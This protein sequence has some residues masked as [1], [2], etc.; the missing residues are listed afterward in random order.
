MGIVKLD[1]NDRKILHALDFYS[2]KSN[3][4]IGKE[5]RLSKEVVNYRI[6]R[7]AELG[8]LEYFQTIVNVAKLGYTTF[9]VYLRLQDA[10]HATVQEITAFLIQ[11]PKI[12]W[13]AN[14][15][16]SWNLEFAVWGRN[17][18][19]FEE[20]WHEFLAKYRPFVSASQISVYTRLH[21]F[22]RSF[23]VAGKEE[24]PEE[25]VIG[26]KEIAKYDKTDMGILQALGANGRAPLLEIA[27]KAGISP[28]VAAYRIKRMEKEGIILGYKPMIN[29]AKIGYEYYK[30]N[31][32]LKNFS[33]V[34]RMIAW[35]RGNQNIVYVDETIAGADFE[36]DAQVPSSTD[37][38]ALIG[39]FM[40]KF[41]A[42]I[43]SYDYFR[44]LNELKI[45]YVP[46]E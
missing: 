8:V 9:R 30:V 17:I 33:Q 39:E 5:V 12:W 23:L 37:Y 45:I 3:A 13:I 46:Q 14:S 34:D 31:V 10:D 20:V 2:R 41:G 11:H 22:R 26:G 15:T 36:F 19:E 27:A 43:R 6:R 42:N 38:D 28:K 1:L 18:Y 44:A 24:V 35:A 7:L 4:E 32:N 40:K 21:H 16:G 25:R 29:L